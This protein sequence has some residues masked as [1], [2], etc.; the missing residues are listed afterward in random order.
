MARNIRNW[1][2]VQRIH[3]SF[4]LLIFML[5][6]FSYEIPLT[7]MSWNDKIVGF[8]R[9]FVWGTNLSTSIRTVLS[10]FQSLVCFINKSI[11]LL[12]IYRLTLHSYFDDHIKKKESDF[13]AV[14]KHFRLLNVTISVVKCNFIGRI[15]TFS[16]I[17]SNVIAWPIEIGFHIKIIVEVTSSSYRWIGFQINFA[18]K[19]LLEMLPARL[20]G[21]R[22]FLSVLRT[23]NRL[24]PV[25]L[26]LFAFL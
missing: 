10:R 13:S 17:K 3:S 8:S 2:V 15:A 23:D 24:S 18:W 9:E 25:S 5:R 14:S 1:W 20:N 26:N 16:A 19:I 12:I 11:V 6:R 22:V 7:K 4:T 21:Q